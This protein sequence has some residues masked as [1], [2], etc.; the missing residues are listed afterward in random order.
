MSASPLR[1]ALQAMSS[2]AKEL[3]HPVSTSTLGPSKPKYQLTRFGI[4]NGDKHV[5]AC[6]GVWSGSRKDMVR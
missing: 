4:V 6:R 3:E 2:A 1:I 5:A